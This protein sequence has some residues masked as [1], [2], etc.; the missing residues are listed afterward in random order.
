M[1]KH[2]KMRREFWRTTHLFIENAVTNNIV[3][4]QALGLCPI[5]AISTTLQN[6]VVMAACT[7][8]VMLPLSLMTALLSNSLPKWLRP[9]V[10]VI[11][12]ALILVGCS[13]VL[14][15]YIST[16]LFAVL[17]HFI[18]LI[19]VNMLYNRTVGFSSIIHPVATVMDALGST[20]G[21]GLVICGVSALREVMAYGTLWGVSVDAKIVIPQTAA[22]FVAFI[23]LAFLAATLQW[24]RQRISAFFR[25]KEEDDE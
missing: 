1:S 13:F 23:L 11:L 20:V 2:N 19:A 3:L 5:I 9:A 24:T 12:A 14:E 17:H 7:A 15:R 16:E 25:R 4:I 8:A 18:P 22:P 21:F 10:Y 6:G